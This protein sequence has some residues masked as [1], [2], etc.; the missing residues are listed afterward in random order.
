MIG[1]ESVTCCHIGPAQSQVTLHHCPW[2]VA[3]CEHIYVMSHIFVM[4]FVFTVCYFV[5]IS[6]L[7]IISPAFGFTYLLN[8]NWVQISNIQD[9]CSRLWG[10]ASATFLTG[11][12]T[13]CCWTS[14]RVTTRDTGDL[15]WPHTLLSSSHQMSVV[16]GTPITAPAGW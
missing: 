3:E 12:A 8:F 9:E 10:S 16:S 11:A 15:W 14:S 6:A 5:K 7:S 13:S 2:S 4:P 1:C